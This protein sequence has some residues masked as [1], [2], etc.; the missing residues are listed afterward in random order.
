MC[1]AVVAMRLEVVLDEREVVPLEVGDGCEA[2]VDVLLDLSETRL[3][4]ID[5]GLGVGECD[6]HGQDA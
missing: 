5:S 6:E 2:V 3:D 4:T 1:P